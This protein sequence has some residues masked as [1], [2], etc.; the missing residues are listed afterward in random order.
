MS[1]AIK[2]PLPKTIFE[3]LANTHGLHCVSIY[4]PMNKNG[5]EQN[6]RIAQATLKQCLKKVHKDLAHHEMDSQE[7]KKYLKP[8]EALLTDIE[9][10]RNPSDGLAI[11]LDKNGLNYY[12]LPISFEMK[13]NVSD[14]FYLLPLLPLYH[15]DD[16][17]YLL[18]LS[19]DYVKLYEANKYGY[20]DIYI[21]DFAPA[22]LEE[23]V[24]F[25]F[26]PKLYQFRSGQNAQMPG[27]YYG[28]GEGKDDL[29]KELYKF[30]REI[31]KG[32]NKI[33]SN[34]K[35]PLVIAC[36]DPLFGLYKEANTYPNLLENYIA[37]DSEFKNKT[38]LYQE[39]WKLVHPFFEKIKESKLLQYKELAHTPKASYQISEIVAAAI[40]GKIDTLFV[41]NGAD[42]FGVFDK[43]AN[44]LMF[45]KKTELNNASLND[46]SAVS[47]FMQGG[48]VYFLAPEEMP[49]K[50]QPMNALLRY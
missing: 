16:D 19:Q 42:E 2:H 27:A 43:Q 39:S 35:A 6:A 17:Y 36:A 31:D 25:D 7:I 44:R 48:K 26:K 11:F 14:H 41:Q 13:T 29:K 8:I 4:L 15:E 34:K 5:K 49:D 24:G 10:W 12:T 45:R 46:L 30:F 20:Q 47:T 1:V 21:E 9:L 50:G 3:N 22:Q 18:E 32:I 40:N 28:M 37:G 33:I 38:K 23:A